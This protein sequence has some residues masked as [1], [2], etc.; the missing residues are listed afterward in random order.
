[1]AQNSGS[2][3]SGQ[4]VSM[5]PAISISRL[6]M[7]FVV[8]MEMASEHLSQVHMEELTARMEEIRVKVCMMIRL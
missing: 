4:N 3:A 7:E 6:P 2:S 5:R 8:R 1:M